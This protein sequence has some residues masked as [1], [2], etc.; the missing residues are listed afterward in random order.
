MVKII[1][2]V[3]SPRTAGNTRYLVEKALESAKNQEQK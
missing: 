1:G 2:I 3:G